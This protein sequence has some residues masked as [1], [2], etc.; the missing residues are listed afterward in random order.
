VDRRI[1]KKELSSG[2]RW[3]NFSARSF[4]RVPISWLVA[5]ICFLVLV[6]VLVIVFVSAFVSVCVSVGVSI[7][8]C[9]RRLLP[10]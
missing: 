5:T 7:N 8:R 2:N 6:S 4:G 9:R 3:L 10:V 1:P